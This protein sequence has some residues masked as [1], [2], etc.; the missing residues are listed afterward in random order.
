MFVL[1]AKRSIQ[2]RCFPTL[3]TGRSRK[4]GARRIVRTGENASAKNE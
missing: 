3:A 2:D 1:I 4:D